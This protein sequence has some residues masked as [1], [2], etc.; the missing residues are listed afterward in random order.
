MKPAHAPPRARRTWRETLGTGLVLLVIWAQAIV[1]L[2][3]LRMTAEAAPLGLSAICGHAPEAPAIADQA[4]LALGCHA[5]PLCAA[6]LAGP[7]LPAPPTVARPL[8][9]SAVAWPIPPP[10]PTAS[11][12]RIPGQPRAPPA[13]L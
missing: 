6:G 2:A 1:P 8:R 13:S 11:R 5:C 9:R 10:V 4:P 3:A 12:T 7:I